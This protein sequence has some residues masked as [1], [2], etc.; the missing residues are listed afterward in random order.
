[1]PPGWLKGHTPDDSST[2]KALPRVGLPIV[3]GRSPNTATS[4]S[5]V[6]P[7]PP[8]MFS[9]SSCTQRCSFA[10]FTPGVS[11]RLMS[12]RSGSIKRGFLY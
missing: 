3:R 11:S 4:P 1:M 2:K 12:E 10:H 6:P 7:V 8:E 9:A 5:M